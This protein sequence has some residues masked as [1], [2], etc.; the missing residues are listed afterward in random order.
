MNT[1]S[2]VVS[3]FSF[4]PFPLPVISAEPSKFRERAVPSSEGV[5]AYS[6]FLRLSGALRPKNAFS[7]FA[8]FTFT[9]RVA[10]ML[11]KAP[12]PTSA[13]VP[14]AALPAPI[15]NLRRSMLFSPWFPRGPTPPHLTSTDRASVAPRL[16]TPKRGHPFCMHWQ[17]RT[18]PRPANGQQR[19]ESLTALS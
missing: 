16:L 12:L 4:R 19:A 17:N 3:A 9:A 18:Q 15:K 7:S 10:W 11:V 2:N 8:T 14:T 6:P 13:L 1:S 5:V